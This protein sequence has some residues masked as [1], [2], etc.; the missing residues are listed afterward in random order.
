V[1]LRPRV[2]AKFTL[3]LLRGVSENANRLMRKRRVVKAMEMMDDLG[4]M[5]GPVGEINVSDLSN[6]VV[7]ERIDGRVVTLLLGEERFRARMSY[8][9]MSYREIK[10]KRP[11]ATTFD[12]RL[13]GVIAAD[14]TN[15]FAEGDQND[16]R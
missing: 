13:D 1:I 8:F 16:V 10:A 5:A 7:S 14:K 9:L 2:P 3:P 12:L 15:H 4:E 11:D 6:L